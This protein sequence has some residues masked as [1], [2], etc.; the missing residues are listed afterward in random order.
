VKSSFLKSFERDL[1]KIR[2]PAV[3]NEVRS[4]ILGIDEA[5]ELRSIPHLKK[6]S[7][8]GPYFRIRVGEYRIGLRVD[9]GTVT[10]VRLLPRRDIY[11][12]FP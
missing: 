2:D 1:R 10:F 11:R 3:L 4:A 6:L 9:G 8:G 7:G 12:Y 5:Q